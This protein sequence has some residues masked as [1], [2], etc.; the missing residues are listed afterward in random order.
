VGCLLAL[1]RCAAED[2]GRID[3][4]G[5][6]EPITRL[7]ILFRPPGSDHMIVE[8]PVAVETVECPVVLALDRGFGIVNQPFPQCCDVAPAAAVAVGP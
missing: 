8:G 4:A 6:I 2:R 1:C 5:G 7:Q 3:T